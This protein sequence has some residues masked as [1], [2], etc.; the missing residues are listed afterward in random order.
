MKAYFLFFYQLPAVP[1]GFVEWEVIHLEWDVPCLLL[2]VGL[3]CNRAPPA[4]DGSTPA[5]PSVGSHSPTPCVLQLYYRNTYYWYLKQQWEGDRLA[6]LGFD[7]ESVNRLFMSQLISSGDKVAIPALRIVEIGWDLNS[8]I[9]VSSGVNLTPS[10]GGAGKGLARRSIKDGPAAAVTA[11]GG[12]SGAG[13]AAAATGAIGAAASAGTNGGV[14][15]GENG[16]VAAGHG[17]TNGQAGHHQGGVS[18]GHGAFAED[19]ANLPPVLVTEMENR[20]LTEEERI[21]RWYVEIY[22]LNAF[23]TYIH[24]VERETR[25]MPEILGIER[26]SSWRRCS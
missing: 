4:A 1:A 14:T 23:D 8:C 19:K 24:L 22:I 16:S 17:S 2:A 26:E 12:V 7:G 9:N 15:H 20:K 3:R 11:G 25:L 21:R 13:S 18:G 5:A 10:M 6:F